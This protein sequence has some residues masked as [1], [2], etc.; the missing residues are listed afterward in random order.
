MA[1]VSGLGTTVLVTPQP[2]TWRLRASAPGFWSPEV[3][4]ETPAREPVRL[5]LWPAAP[6]KG[7]LQFPEG[8]D[9]SDEV[10]LI[11]NR[12]SDSP[13]GALESAEVRCPLIDSRIESCSLPVGK[14]H[15]RIKVAKYIPQYRWGLELEEGKPVDLGKIILK[16]GTSLFGQVVTSDGSA[17]S[18][19]QPR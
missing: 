13:E 6:G 18:P 3:R 19:R 8:A 14:W 17:L 15:L 1:M 9:P 4:V 5:T 7:V 11:M 16:Q 12:V 2:G 10:R